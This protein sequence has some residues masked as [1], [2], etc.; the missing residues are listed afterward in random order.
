MSFL[1]MGIHIFVV[2]KTVRVTSM[3]EKT[4][5]RPA[6]PFLLTSVPRK[7]MRAQNIPSTVTRNSRSYPVMNCTQPDPLRNL[8]CDGKAAACAPAQSVQGIAANRQAPWQ[9]NT[10]WRTNRWQRS[11]AQ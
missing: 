4:S 9:E 1:I 6:Q 7:G 10:P 8:A 2:E 11:F 3:E 5:R